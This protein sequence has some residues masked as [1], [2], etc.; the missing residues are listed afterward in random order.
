M[1]SEDVKILLIDDDADNIKNLSSLLKLY[2]FEV[3]C[4]HSGREGLKAAKETKPGI[5][6]LDVWLPDIDGYRVASELKKDPETSGIPLIFISGDGALDSEKSL[7]CGADYFITKPIDPKELN[8]KIH[9]L[10]EK[11]NRTPA[12]ISKKIRVFIVDDD[13]QICDILKNALLRKGYD[14]DTLYDGTNILDSVKAAQPDIIF[15]D[16]SFPVGPNG[17]EICRTLK[18]NPGTKKIPV[19]MMTANED[20]Q[21][22]DKCFEIGAED[23]IFKPFNLS[24]LIL[25]IKKHTK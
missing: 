18:S 14:V 23:Y 8:E 25:R 2:G 4:A 12:S 19:V 20:A 9:K 7:A 3:S 1:G 13:R 24:D 15:L 6:L 5:I 22:V 21:S 17:I 11:N 16:F 10:T